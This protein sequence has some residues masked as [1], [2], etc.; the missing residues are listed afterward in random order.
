[1]SRPERFPVH[2]RDGRVWLEITTYAGRVFFPM[3]FNPAAGMTAHGARA[4]ADCLA[5]AADAAERE[6]MATQSQLD[7]PG[8]R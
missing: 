8:V 7:L 4:L 1:M 5:A 6:T 3:A 2:A